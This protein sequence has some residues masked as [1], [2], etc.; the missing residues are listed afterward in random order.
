MV[1]AGLLLGGLSVSQAQLSIRITD[2]TSTLTVNDQGT[3]DSDSADLNK[4]SIDG[5]TLNSTFANLT[6]GS[7]LAASSNFASADDFRDLITSGF[8]VGS[9]GAPTT[10]YTITVSQDNF[11]VPASSR[12]FSS[13]GNF[14]FLNEPA[15]TT[16]TF[17]A[18]V[19]PGNTLFAQTL[20]DTLFSYSSA[21]TSNNSGGVPSFSSG[22]NFGPGTYTQTTVATLTV[23]SQGRA[24]YQGNTDVSA[25]PEPGTIAMLV[26][27]GISGS[28]FVLRRRRK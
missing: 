22:F 24:Q 9:V 8:L 5:A 17:Q 11:T 20:K 12:V 25:V 10:T 16:S 18:G 3:G 28:A 6:T 4:V 15:G 23:V 14:S 2:G 13:T 7:N 19:D 27:M 1:A 26:G 21:G